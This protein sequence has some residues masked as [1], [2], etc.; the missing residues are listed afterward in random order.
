MHS[1][2]QWQLAGA[3]RLFPSIALALLAAAWIWLTLFSLTPAHADPEITGHITW[4]DPD[5]EEFGIDSDGE[6]LNFVVDDD[7][8]IL[9]D[10]QPATLEDVQPNEWVVSCVYRISNSRRLCIRLEIETPPEEEGLE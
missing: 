4:V 6:E 8:V 10:H 3:R 1:P 7:T 2:G 9:R 5:A